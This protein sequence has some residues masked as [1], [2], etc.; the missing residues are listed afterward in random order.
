MKK[1]IILF[2]CLLLTG[3]YN[4]K[5]VSDLAFV[6]SL[7]LDYQDN[8][9]NII[10]EIEENQ[11][12]NKFSSYILEGTGKTIEAAIQNASLSF[13]KDLYFINLNIL[14]I[15]TEAANKKLSN[16]LD[17]VTR[18]NNF[19]FDFNIA[20]CD[21]PKEAIE[22]IIK[23][24]EIFGK[25]ISNLFK[26]TDS[27]IINIKLDNLLNNYLNKDYDIIL[28][29]I[30]IK[31]NTII[32]DKAAIFKDNIIIDTLNKE[33]LA[34]YNILLNNHRDYYLEIDN[35]I[36]FKTSYYQTTICFKNNTLYIIP[37]L[38]GTFLESVSL[39]ENKIIDE[40]NINFNKK[41]ESFIN[42]L[43]SLQSDPIG[44]KR[45]TKN[46]K[47]IKYRISTNIIL[48]NKSLIYKGVSS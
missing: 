43:I 4:Y 10:L 30:N 12:D 7:A 45:Y 24:E 13:N 37:T 23:Q 48:E 31:E 20:I 41:L 9:F 18:D 34:L 35:N 3:C 5:E 36:V 22:N 25:Y 28:P 11:K 14:L 44:L 47:A 19:S 26:N 1:I 21:K 17:Y 38:T 29:I 46:K 39:D 27:N 8:N 15:S 32:I 40:V 2:A 42:N 16:I 6:S 33:S